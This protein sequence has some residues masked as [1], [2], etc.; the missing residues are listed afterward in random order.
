M[1]RDSEEQ[2]D[3]I[4]T[5]DFEP[6]SVQAG[7]QTSLR[8]ILTDIPTPANPTLIAV[9]SVRPDLAR[10]NPEGY[11]IA[12]NGRFKMKDGIKHQLVPI[13]TFYSLSERSAQFAAQG[14]KSQHMASATICSPKVKSFSL[15]GVTGVRLPKQNNVFGYRVEEKSTYTLEVK[16]EEP[17]TADVKMKFQCSAGHLSVPPGLTIPSGSDTGM[18]NFKTWYGGHYGWI[19]LTHYFHYPDKPGPGTYDRF[20]LGVFINPY[21]P[22]SGEDADA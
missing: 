14:N 21:P 4:V 8:I 17:A 5:V 18:T 6:G 16:L 11:E 1:P 15:R 22:L 3:D 20:Q 2:P 19:A 13:D 7:M 12:P 10:P 9:T